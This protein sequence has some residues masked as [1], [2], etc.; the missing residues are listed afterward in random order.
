MQAIP[1]SALIMVQPAFALSVLV[2]LLNGPAAMGQC[3]QPV[4]RGVHRE[5]AVIPLDVAVVARHRPLAEQPALR[6]GVDAMMRGRQLRPARGPVHSDGHKLFAQYGAL[7]LTPGD[8]LPVGLWQG[9]EDG[10]GLHRAAPGGASWVG[11]GRGA[12]AA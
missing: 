3:D 5:I 4:Q 12:V 2:E 6:A 10:L 1:A 8:R 9:L 11:H 7:V